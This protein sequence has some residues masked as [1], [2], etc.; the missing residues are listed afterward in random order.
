M[1][2]PAQAANGHDKKPSTN[3]K[4]KGGGKWADPEFRRAYNRKWWAER[5]KGKK[6]KEKKAASKPQSD[7]EK[8]EDRTADAIIYLRKAER[9]LKSHPD[10]EETV[11]DL[12]TKLALKAL[13]GEL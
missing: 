10:H 2:D 4:D 1:A 12:M 5:G 13:Q 9:W 3:K 7:V 8:L 11:A 6:R